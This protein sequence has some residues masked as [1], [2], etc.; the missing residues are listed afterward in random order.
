M[1]RSWLQVSALKQG[2]EQC[3]LH[4]PTRLQTRDYIQPRVAPAAENTDQTDSTV[5]ASQAHN[6][7]TTL[8]HAQTLTTSAAMG[9]WLSAW[10]FLGYVLAKVYAPIVES[11]WSVPWVPHSPRLLCS[12]VMAATVSRVRVIK[13]ALSTEKACYIVFHCSTT[14]TFRL[15]PTTTMCSRKSRRFGHVLVAN[16]AFLRKNTFNLSLQLE[17]AI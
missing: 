1:A 12:K 5:T 13:R 6:T 7:Q 17:S 2:A 14:D 3:C 10:G 16:N 9:Y 4:A 15:L 11:C 8:Q